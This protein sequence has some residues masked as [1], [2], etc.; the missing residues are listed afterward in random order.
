VSKPI[1][2][3][4]AAR[5]G[6]TAVAAGST[7]TAVLTAAGKVL[8]LGKL[9]TNSNSSRASSTRN[10]SLT[11]P[12]DATAASSSSDAAAAGTEGWC[13]VALPDTVHIKHI[14]AGQQHLVLSDGEQVWAVGRWMD[15]A[16]AEAGCAPAEAPQQLLALPSAGI[17]RLAAGMHSSACVDGDGQLWMWGRLLDQAQAQAA[18]QAGLVLPVGGGGSG[19]AGLMQLAEAARRVGQVDW[20]WAGFGAA[21]PRKVEGLQG[22]QSVALGGWHALVLAD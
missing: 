7:F 14:A 10:I 11:P 15:Q 5:G 6:A 1:S 21:G 2:D 13:E 19:T 20:D 18:V 3:A 12:A 8:L 16:G 9:Y 22:V 17:V 4:I